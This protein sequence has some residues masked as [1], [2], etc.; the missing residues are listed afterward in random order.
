MKLYKR[1]QLANIVCNPYKLEIR[2]LGKSDWH[3]YYKEKPMPS[4]RVFN[5]T[6]AVEGI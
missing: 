2:Q 4:R 1:S 6:F 3:D 5:T